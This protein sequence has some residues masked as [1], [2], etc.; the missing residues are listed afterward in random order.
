MILRGA[1]CRSWSPFISPVQQASPPERAHTQQHSPSWLGGARDADVAP[2][3]APLCMLGEESRPGPLPAADHFASTLSDGFHHFHSGCCFFPQP[4]HEDAAVFS[5]R[6]QQEGSRTPRSAGDA[7]GRQQR[8]RLSVRSN[9]AFKTNGSWQVLHQ[10]T[11]TPEGTCHGE[12]NHSASPTFL[13]SSVLARMNYTS[14]IL[15]HR[16]GRIK[17]PE[18]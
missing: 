5:R 2:A 3:T 4:K 6:C 9:S 18:W 16:F 14:S 11:E 8:D 12:L 7:T 13:S 10:W 17:A 1:R 15:S